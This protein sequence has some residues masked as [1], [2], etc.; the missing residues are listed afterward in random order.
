MNTLGLAILD[1]IYLTVDRNRQREITPGKCFRVEYIYKC[2]FSLYI[3]QKHR[4][5][6]VQEKNT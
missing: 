4:S 3:T 2:T 1:H 6:Y 5:W